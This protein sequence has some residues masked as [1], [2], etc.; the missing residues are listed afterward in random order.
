[1]GPSLQ[2]AG[3]LPWQPS[4]LTITSSPWSTSPCV[5]SLPVVTSSPRSPLPMVT[6]PCG[7]LPLWSPLPVVTFPEVT[8]RSPPCGHL[9]PVVTLSSRSPLPMLISPTSPPH[10]HFSPWSPLSLRSLSPSYLSLVTCPQVTSFWR[11]L[12]PLRSPP[13]MV[14]PRPRGHFSSCSH[15]HRHEVL[16]SCRSSPTPAHT[17]SSTV[18]GS[19]P[20]DLESH[21]PAPADELASL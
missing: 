19:Q 8:S 13:C 21:R 18:P 20:P 16:F 5:T 14:T 3:R 6:S 1:M 2:P 17:V 11:S 9:S 4:A 12:P 10:G 15:T 7:H